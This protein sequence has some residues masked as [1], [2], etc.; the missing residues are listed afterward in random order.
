MALVLKAVWFSLWESYDEK[1][2]GS[3]PPAYT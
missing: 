2:L 1:A 3:N